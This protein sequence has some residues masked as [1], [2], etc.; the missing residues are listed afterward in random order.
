MTT[1]SNGTWLL[2]ILASNQEWKERCREEVDRAV[3]KHRQSPAQSPSDILDT[4]TL[5]DWESEFSIIYVCLREAIRL[6]MP[7]ALFRKNTSGRDIAIGDT[8]EVIPDGS[9]ATYL[10]DE[11]HMN[12]SFYPDPQRFDPSRYLDDGDINASEKK[13][14][15]TFVG[16]GSG[17]HPCRKHSFQ[18]QVQLPYQLS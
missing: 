18:A 4:L 8:G 1:G 11:V 2:I 10:M 7:G 16:W 14:P 3:A 17:L 5:E 12:P 13:E 6:A 9:F 15:H